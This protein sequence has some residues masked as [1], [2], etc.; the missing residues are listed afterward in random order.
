MN[1]AMLTHQFG[2]GPIAN[3]MGLFLAALSYNGRIS[4][5]VTSDRAMMP[6]SDFFADCIRSA[7]DELCQ[8]LPESP[9]RQRKARKQKHS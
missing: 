7:F 2:M 8:A 3:N 9:P 4:F 1:G 6:D 5:S